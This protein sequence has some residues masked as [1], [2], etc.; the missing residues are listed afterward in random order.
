MSR[1]TGRL[2]AAAVTAVLA[3]SA[4]DAEA[5]A[6]ARLK[7]FRVPTADSQPRDI[8]NGSDGNRWFT[9]GTEFTNAPAKIA[10]SRRVATSPSSHPT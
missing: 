1:R 9:E 10:V 5:A 4:G 7:Q 6:G 2:L 3:F 8:T